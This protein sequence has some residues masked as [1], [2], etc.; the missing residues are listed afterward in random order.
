MHMRT[1]TRENPNPKAI[2][3]WIEIV[4]LIEE[5]PTGHLRRRHR[6][7]PNL[8]VAITT[9]EPGPALD[10]RWARRRAKSPGQY[11]R[12]RYDLMDTRVFTSK[13]LAAKRRA[14]VSR[15]LMNRG[16]TVN[17]DLTRWNVYV[18]E[19][20]HSHLPDCPGW[21]YVGMSSKPASQRVWEH[22]TGARNKRGP[23]FSRDAHKYFV[24][25]RP[26][27]GRPHTHFS[28]EAA[29]QA[30]AQLRIVL[31]DRGYR[32]SGGTERYEEL[33]ARRAAWRNP[34]SEP[35]IE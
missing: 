23:L 31:E 20:D 27:I 7:L 30:E 1:H 25:W 22:M 17:G 33:K 19:L 8:H 11:G 15:S 9:V 16:F 14:R 13:T 28:R 4:E 10:R 34:M 5:R 21:F 18:I 2:H 3:Y 29:L 35:K 26:D 24:R 32:V 6:A 12:I